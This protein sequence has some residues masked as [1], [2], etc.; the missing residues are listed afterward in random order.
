[1]ET[2]EF[3]APLINNRAYNTI[4]LLLKS[5]SKMWLRGEK[6]GHAINFSVANNTEKSFGKRSFV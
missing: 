6:K 3:R 4:I 1:M 2:S 5:E